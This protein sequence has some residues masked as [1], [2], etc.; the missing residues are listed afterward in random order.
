MR[1][2]IRF[3]PVEITLRVE[4]TLYVSDSHA[5]VSNLHSA[6]ENLILHVETNLLRVEITLERVVITLVSDKKYTRLCGNHTL[7]VKSHFACGNQSCAYEKPDATDGM[8]S[9]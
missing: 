6:C 4:I 2:G 8:N 5:C 7:R 3:V 1:V 9:P